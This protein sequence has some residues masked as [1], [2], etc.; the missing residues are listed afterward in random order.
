MTTSPKRRLF[1]QLYPAYVAICLLSLAAASW[2]A[3]TALRGFFL[4]QTR[5]DL[6]V[7]GQLI[8]QQVERYLQPPI[9]AL[10]DQLCKTTGRR[11]STRITVILPDGRV[12]GDS[13]ENPNNMENHGKRPEVLQAMQAGVGSASR[14]SSTLRVDMLYVA[15]PAKRGER[16]AAIVRTSFSLA[17]I[18]AR[19]KRIQSRIALA[20]L[21]IALVTAL[22]CLVAA[23]RISRPIEEMRATAERFAR[24]D[25]SGRLPPSTTEEIS[26]LA[27]T[28]NRMAK[29]LAEK[30]ETIEGQRAEL[31]T[32]FASMREGI[33]AVDAKERII[34][35]NQ[36]AA[37]FCGL[38]ADKVEGRLVQE[39]VRNPDLHRLVQRALAVGPQ[40]EK[41]IVLGASNER[42][43][44]VHCTPLGRGDS[45]PL[46]TLVMLYDVTRLR[47]L[48]IMR[49]DFVANVSHEIKTPLTAVKGYVETLRQDGFDDPDQTHRFLAIVS[50]H[51]DRLNAIVDDLLNL[52]RIEQASDAGTLNFQVVRLAEVLKAAIQACRLH[53]AKAIAITLDCDESLHARIDAVLFEQAAVNLID[54]AVKFSPAKSTVTV[55]VR[56]R[57][58]DIQITFHDQGIGIAK[59]HTD[60]I[61]ERF[62]RV[63]TSRSRSLGGTGLGLAIVKHI[64][65]AHGGQVAVESTPGQGSTFS[66]S[67]PLSADRE[68]A[69][70]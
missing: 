60:R 19:L 10:I 15:V 27:D 40:A 6:T 70:R 16:T 28:L 54:N 14:Y 21:V 44:R 5:S 45:A 39:V 53:A 68:T 55:S 64:V 67:L 2:Y 43:L 52:S 9:P 18:D 37:E 22:V 23:H 24:G 61:F 31:E 33:M 38:E 8:A 46:G 66:I 58:T 47:R 11:T 51:V 62:Y 13:I 56:Q 48:E 63:D 4:D 30:L 57:Q 7:R 25:L 32:V 1:W 17:S 20:G 3:S 42:V 69:A 59:A 50:K 26:A 35:I 12:V 49:R 36:A 34:K 29:A 41:E 65:T